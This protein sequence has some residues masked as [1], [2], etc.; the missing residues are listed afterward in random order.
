MESPV[1]HNN[2]DM[3]CIILSWEQE[4][5]DTFHAVAMSRSLFRKH[6]YYGGEGH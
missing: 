2:Y 6:P 3:M 4:S 1:T 5:L